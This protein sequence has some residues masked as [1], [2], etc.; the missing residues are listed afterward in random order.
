MDTEQWTEGNRNYW[1]SHFFR[2]FPDEAIETVV[3]R[4]AT[5]P[6]PLTSVF[7]EWMEGA[8]ADKPLDATAFPHRDKAFSFTV[9][10][11]WTDPEK[12]DEY[13]GWAQE[14]HE[15]VEPHAAEG[16]Y[17]NYMDK[18]EDERVHTAYG[19]RYERLV[20]LKNKWDS[21]NLFRTNQNIEPTV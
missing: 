18:D 11:I 13:I 5:L 16:V 9:A 19:E 17:V 2:E 15:A 3:E 1:K 12:D 10:P 4:L 14:F 20:K 7:I 6:T 21:G 8:I